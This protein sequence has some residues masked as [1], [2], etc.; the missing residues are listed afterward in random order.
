MHTQHLLFP[1][2]HPPN[3]DQ[4]RRCWTSMIVRGPVFKR[5]MSVSYNIIWCVFFLHSTLT[6]KSVCH[7][8]KNEKQRY[9]FGNEKAP[10]YLFKINL[11]FVIIA[12]ILLQLSPVTLEWTLEKGCIIYWSEWCVKNKSN[13]R[14]KRDRTTLRLPVKQNEMKWKSILVLK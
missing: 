14:N 6:C 12:R 7:V 3:T 5:D 2:V 11:S 4:A 1:S 8:T 10:D 13:T 9:S